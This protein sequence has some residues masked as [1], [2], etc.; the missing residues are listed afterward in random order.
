MSWHWLQIQSLYR[1]YGVAIDSTDYE[2]V[3]LDGSFQEP[4]EQV[5]PSVSRRCRYPAFRLRVRHRNSLIP[6]S[7]TKE[8]SHWL[9]PP[10]WL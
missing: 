2:E 1:V 4:T 7:R 9:R 10:F 6:L 5:R 3:S 8:V